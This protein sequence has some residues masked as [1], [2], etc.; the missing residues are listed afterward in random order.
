MRLEDVP[1]SETMAPE[2][3]APPLRHLLW[4][5][6]AGRQ[7]RRYHVFDRIA[8]ARLVALDALF[9]RLPVDVAPAFAERVAS[10]VRPL[11]RRRV[12]ARRIAHNLSVLA[13]E[14]PREGRA[15]QT[16]VANWW[17]NAGRTVAEYACVERYRK[18][19]RVTVEGLDALRDMGLADGQFIYVSVHL[20]SFE[21]LGEVVSR[22]FQRPCVGIWEPETNRFKNRLL[23]RLRKR[24]G[25]H[26]FPPGRRSAR[27]IHRCVVQGGCDILCYV[28]EVRDRQIHLPLFG[29]PLPDRGN[30]VN[31][32]KLA[33][34]S[35]APLIPI[36]ML[37]DGKGG[38]RVRLHPPLPLDREAPTGEAID[39]AL[40]EIDRF[41]DPI[42]RAHLDQ[43]WM[44]SEVRLPDFVAKPAWT[45]QRRL[46][47]AAAP[48]T[49]SGRGTAPGSPRG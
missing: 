38:F 44:L 1:F 19:G 31:A 14:G 29:R 27:H 21:L 15:L 2:P 43:W 46:N 47:R 24:Y 40:G 45:G 7:A 35:G 10:A 16:A 9:R 42:V 33:L 25:F 30:A 39:K 26:V 12:Y 22:G 6:D 3:E 32:V 49:A 28:D 5:G 34:R 18:A 37:R 17:Q 4:R 48:G 13:P 23:S 36:Y 41:F 8:G 11:Q 20:G